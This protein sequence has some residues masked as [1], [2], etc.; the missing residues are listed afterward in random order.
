MPT[1]PRA[2]RPGAALLPRRR[3]RTR[4]RR[5]QKPRH[6]LMRR[7]RTPPDSAARCFL[8]P[9][10]LRR[11][12]RRRA[13][14]A[15]QRARWTWR[16]EGGQ[17]CARVRFGVSISF[18]RG[19]RIGSTRP[20]S[21]QDGQHEC[22]W[23]IMTVAKGT[24]SHAER[25]HADA[26]EG[27]L[28]QPG[29][30][31]HAPFLTR[32][33]PCLH[34]SRAPAASA[35]RVRAVLRATRSASTPHCAALRPRSSLAGAPRRA[36][37]RAGG[38]STAVVSNGR[39]RIHTTFPDESEMVRPSL[40]PAPRRTPCSAAHACMRAPQVEEYDV[41]TEELLGACAVQHYQHEAADRHAA[42]CASGAAR[43]RSDG[44]KSGRCAASARRLLLQ[45]PFA[46]ADARCA[47]S[48]AQYLVGEAPRLFN[49]HTTTLAPS[50][51]NVRPPRARVATR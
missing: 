42:Q 13:P 1:A 46:G 3:A 2:R 5:G 44:S 39:R 45:S 21:E 16:A 49:P 12:Q 32:C 35:D 15:R 23:A 11:A 30:N 43:P 4:L 41:T 29:T 38:T 24:A 34:C 48:A 47:R 8:P 25:G 36:M 28:G 22:R 26:R 10:P 51:S 40:K 19:L 37:L 7:A 27:T 9:S 31:A 6:A 18:R 50:L 33:T 14:R 17:T 20:C